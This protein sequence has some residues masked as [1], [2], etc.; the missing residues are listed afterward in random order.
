MELIHNTKYKLE[1]FFIF[2]YMF[3]KIYKNI[4]ICVYIYIDIKINI[5]KDYIYKNINIG[6]GGHKARGP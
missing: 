2:F 4:Y 3:Y 5:Y 6:H 1:F